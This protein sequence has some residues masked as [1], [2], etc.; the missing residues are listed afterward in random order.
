[1]TFGEDSQG[2]ACKALKSEGQLDE[3]IPYRRLIKMLFQGND[4]PLPVPASAVLVA[5][6]D[7]ITKSID[8]NYFAKDRGRLYCFK[9]LLL[10]SFAQLPAVF[11]DTASWADRTEDVIGLGPGGPCQNRS[12]A[13]RKRSHAL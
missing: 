12:D 2:Q 8:H 7:A 13:W 3:I 1:M 5:L 4:E 10:T 6:H 9:D 11:R